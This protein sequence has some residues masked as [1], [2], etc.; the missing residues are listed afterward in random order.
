MGKRI[1]KL[2]EN[3]SNTFELPKDIVLDVSKIII[4]GTGQVTVENHK[5]IIEYSEEI[6][7]INIGSSVM[8]L[9]GK[10]LSIKTILQEEI[11]ITG[12]ITNIEF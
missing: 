7:R 11:T 8:K 12:E 6:I 3:I 4:I 9:C 5:G 1:Y 10:N 2:K